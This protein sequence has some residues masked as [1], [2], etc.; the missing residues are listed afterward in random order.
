M[1][2]SLARNSLP[3]ISVRLRRH[4]H[5]HCHPM[6]AAAPPRK[7]PTLEVRRAQVGCIFTSLQT[8]RHRL[9]RAGYLPRRALDTARADP[10]LG[11]NSPCVSRT[12]P[13]DA[14]SR[15]GRPRSTSTPQPHPRRPPSGYVEGII[16]NYVSKAGYSAVPTYETAAFAMVA[17]LA[18]GIFSLIFGFL[19]LLR[20]SKIAC[21]R[22]TSGA[23]RAY[24]HQADATAPR[25]RS[26]H[27]PQPHPRRRPSGYAE[28]LSVNRLKLVLQAPQLTSYDTAASSMAV[29]RVGRVIF[30]LFFFGLVLALHIFEHMLPEKHLPP[31]AYPHGTKIEV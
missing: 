6:D 1:S 14:A 17:R 18:R 22:S 10:D 8:C 7:V 12:H 9:A 2:N 11:C 31:R 19:L 4:L 21:C 5:S 13:H 3:S 24:P 29:A 26:T 30:F 25:T 20:C 27:I 28:G 16:I 15:H 23:F